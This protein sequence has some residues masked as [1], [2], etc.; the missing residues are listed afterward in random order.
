ML[1]NDLLRIDVDQLTSTPGSG[2]IVTLG[3]E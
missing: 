3:F 2:A 1:D